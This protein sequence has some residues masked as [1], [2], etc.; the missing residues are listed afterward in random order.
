[1]GLHFETAKLLKKE[2]V[3]FFILFTF[4]LC[5]GEYHIVRVF[6]FY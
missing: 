2:I 5:H 4:S 1:M 3:H 6:L